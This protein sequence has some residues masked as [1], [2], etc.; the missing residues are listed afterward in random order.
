MRRAWGFGGI[1][2]I[3]LGGLSWVGLEMSARAH[4]ESPP[5]SALLVDRTGAFLAQLAEPMAGAGGAPR[6][7]YGFWPLP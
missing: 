1:G 6:L 7:D 4:L 3:A 2:L 5:P